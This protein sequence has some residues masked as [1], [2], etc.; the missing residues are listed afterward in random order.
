M[1]ENELSMWR[2]PSL[3]S[4]YVGS[5]EPS[6]FLVDITMIIDLDQPMEVENGI[7]C[8]EI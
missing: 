7:A 5:L 3:N 6:G 1:M 8:G 2:A 4:L